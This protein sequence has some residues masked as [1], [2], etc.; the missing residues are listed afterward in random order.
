M[1]AVRADATPAARVPATALGGVATLGGIALTVKRRA[2]AVAVAAAGRR[3]AGC[4]PVA[5]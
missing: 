1:S 2:C 4:R 5:R 3:T